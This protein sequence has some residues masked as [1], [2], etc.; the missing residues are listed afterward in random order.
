MLN[1]VWLSWIRSGTPCGEPPSHSS[2][3]F[4]RMNEKPTAVIS[5]A[6]LGAPRSGR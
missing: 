4:C 6:S 3:T 2:P 5:D 1:T